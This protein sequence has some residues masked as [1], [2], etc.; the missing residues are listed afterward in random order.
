MISATTATMTLS[1]YSDT[2][3]A[4][5]ETFLSCYEIINRDALRWDVRLYKIR[6]GDGQ[7]QAERGEAKQVIWALRRKHKDLCNGYG[8]VVEI[9]EETV[10]VA[11]GWKLPS[12]VT[13]AGY[14]VTLVSEFTTNP[15]DWQHRTVIMG[16]VREGIKGYFKSNRSAHLGDLW[17]DYDRFCQRPTYV[18]GSDFHFC[19]KFGMVAK[20]LVENRWVL[21]PLVSTV[22]LDGR[23]FADYFRAGEVDVLTEMIEAKQA[24]RL[25]RRNRS[26]AVR[27]LRD[28]STQ[29]QMKVGVLELEEPN[30]LNG[31]ASL[32]RYEQAEKAQGTIRCRGFNSPPIDVPYDQVRLILDT[33]I[34]QGD[35]SETILKP[36]DR[37]HLAG[38]LRDFVD[39]AEINGVQIRLANVPVDAASLPTEEVAFPALRVRDQGVT[40]RVIPGPRPVTK[41]ALRARGR[42]RTEALKRFGFLQ[43][44]P[45][46]PLLAWP[47]RF[48]QQRAQRMASDLN[49]LLNGAGIEYQFQSRLFDSVDE[50]NSLVTKNGFDSL[51]AVLPEGWRR[52]FRDDNTHEMI[53]QRIDVPSQC[54]QFDNTLPEA[55][56]NRPHRD[57]VQQD[58][59]LARRIQQ[60]YELCIWNL[61]A[62]LHWIPFAPVDAFSYNVHI[63]LDVGGRHNNR[64]MACLGYGFQSPKDGLLFRP[65]EIRIDVQK[66]E[67]IPTECLTR[68]LLLL[69]E[70]VHAELR[71]TGITPDLERI[72]F[73]RDGR[74]LGDGDN[75][76]EVDAIR[77][78][79]GRLIERGWITEQ[80]VWTAVEL[81]KNAEEWRIMSGSNE[82]SNP[83]VGQCYF[84]FDDVATGLICTTG[85]PYLSQGTAGPLKINIIDVSG[86][87][88]RQQ[89]V[90]DL[91]WEADM[92]F[93][94]PDIG[95]S[96]PWVLH[97]AD[98]GALHAARSYRITGI[99]L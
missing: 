20:V 37:H 99:T 57:M 88:N 97:V 28:G 27:V 35:H 74:L 4:L 80:S 24:N 54:I 66:A 36:A 41:E 50:L 6:R 85:E 81:M 96:L 51:L 5:P 15:D 92:C 75:W 25:N 23:S 26:T 65:E 84:P 18:N 31:I 7:S 56:V 42:Q 70:Q 48:G 3:D 82:V 47:K 98:A 72:L 34:T 49:D 77:G 43:G 78:V 32:S 53:K 33:Q 9:D 13:E 46:N 29:H 14:R 8:F 19:R 40:E 22:T 45:I 55:W 52:A 73:F 67:P 12:G 38:L 68:G 90:Q 58:Q 87:S 83:L 91:V 44:R 39:G 89:V 2:V 94:K 17:Q 63:G 93:T 79:R 16:I 61:L 76:N 69:I 62:K 10:A 21:Q 86:K 59:K 60:R 64:A 95:M 11:S 30:L 71:Q 1:P